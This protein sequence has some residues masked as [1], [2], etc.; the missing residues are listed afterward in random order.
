[1]KKFVF[2]SII[3]VMLAGGID[4]ASPASA[5]CNW[6]AVGGFGGGRR[7]DGPINRS[8]QFMRCDQGHGMG[9]GGTNCYVVQFGDPN[10]APYIP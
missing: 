8:G 3:G 7:C 10:Q 6:V 2:A 4:L 9:F 5:G 1:M